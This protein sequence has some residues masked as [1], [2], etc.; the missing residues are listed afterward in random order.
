MCSYGTLVLLHRSTLSP[1]A[2][3]PRIS[4]SGQKKRENVKKE[5]ILKISVKSMSLPLLFLWQSDLHS[6]P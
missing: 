1:R 4:V 6:R 3:L 2:P 5:V